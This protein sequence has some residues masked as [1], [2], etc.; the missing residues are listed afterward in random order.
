MFE[1]W[2]IATSMRALQLSGLYRQSRGAAACQKVSIGV[3]EQRA[4][5][6]CWQRRK[7]GLNGCL[8][9]GR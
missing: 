1:G 7:R 6:R 4:S 5:I 3:S 2:C 9:L 8:V